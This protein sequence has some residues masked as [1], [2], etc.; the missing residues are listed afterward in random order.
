MGNEMSHGHSHDGKP[1]HGH[2][3][4]AS[5][6]GHGHSHGA[7]TPAPAP[8]AGHGHSHGGKP[9]H[10]HGGGDSG[11]GHSHAAPAPKQQGHG[12]SHGGDAGHGHSHGG[13][14]GHSHNGKPCHGH[15][16]SEVEM[17]PVLAKKKRAVDLFMTVMMG[18]KLPIVFAHFHKSTKT[19][20]QL[21]AGGSV[22]GG[23]PV[24]NNADEVMSRDEFREVVY[25]INMATAR[26]DRHEVVRPSEVAGME[27]AFLGM[28]GMRV[29][30]D[31]DA[32][33]IPQPLFCRF[34]GMITHRIAMQRYDCIPYLLEEFGLPPKCPKIPLTPADEMRSRIDAYLYANVVPFLSKFMLTAAEENKDAEDPVARCGLR[35]V[36]DSMVAGLAEADTPFARQA[37]TFLEAQPLDQIVNALKVEEEDKDAH[38]R[39]V[40][41][42]VVT[43]MLSM[44][45][46][47]EPET[48]AFVFKR[49]GIDFV[50][51]FEDSIAAD[52]AAPPA[53]PPAADKP[54]DK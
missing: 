3:P 22:S 14:H 5:S 15:G 47:M 11:H 8:T 26:A 49:W 37:V 43:K 33:S 42:H 17:D 38:P 44:L 10:G 7:P 18:P 4:E 53:A 6:G 16:P 23:I 13:D 9:C 27:R 45:L 29:A 19:A 31:D 28:M 32:V 40:V 12:H 48:A 21:A 46:G 20:E 52:P 1:C 35:A 36:V 25:G 51:F 50:V 2:G 24:P 30:G 39:L 41:Y 54:A 34:I